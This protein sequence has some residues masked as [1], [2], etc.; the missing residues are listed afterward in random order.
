MD[1]AKCTNRRL[2]GQHRS[3]TDLDNGTPSPSCSL[4]PNSTF[5]MAWQQYESCCNPNC[6][7]VST[8]E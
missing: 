4:P 8:P 2:E 6:T 7:S 1:L 5:C 3:S